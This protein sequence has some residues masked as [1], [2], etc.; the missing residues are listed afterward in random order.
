MTVENV[1]F[2][3]T[4]NNGQLD[5]SVYGERKN[6]A[7]NPITQNGTLLVPQEAAM[8]MRAY[9][10]SSAPT[11][12]QPKGKPDF[13]ILKQTLLKRGLVEG[14]DFEHYINNDEN[15]C[16]I[17]F[18]KHGKKI[19][20]L[21]WD[22]ANGKPDSYNG[23]TKRYFFV[24]ND[25]EFITADYDK[26]NKF[27]CRCHTYEKN[28]YKNDVISISTTP[29]DFIEYLKAN[30]C[31]YTDTTLPHNFDKN[32]CIRTITTYNPITGN[33]IDVRFEQDTKTN[34][35]T[36]IQKHL[37][38]SNNDVCRRINYCPEGVSV[39]DYKEEPEYKFQT[40][41]Q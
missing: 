27:V 12:P 40:F 25:N 1:Y 13:N 7:T 30:N 4:G 31:K 36:Y 26:D 20:T 18:L 39:I 6:L 29:E 2:R 17:S 9:A 23:F 22:D 19:Q 41:N 38:D 15:F 11:A 5:T 8:A 24:N 21:Y 33:M 37:Y 10:L 34:E 16:S 28:P 3:N 35:V 32:Q 14:R